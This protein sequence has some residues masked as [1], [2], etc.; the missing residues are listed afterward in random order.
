MIEI[1]IN[2]LEESLKKTS[3]GRVLD[4]AT[5]QGGFIKRMEGIFGDFKEIIGIDKKIDNIRKAESEFDD[6]RIKFMQM[7]AGKLDFDSGSFDT[8]MMSHSLHHMD[9]PGTVLEEMLRVLKPS[10]TFIIRELHRSDMNELQKTQVE[11]HH[12]WADIDRQTG[13]SH[14]HTLTYDKIVETLEKLPIRDL[15][16]ARCEEPPVLTDAEDLK[17]LDERIEE[18]FV[19]IRDNLLEESLI[20][21]GEAI[22]NR[23]SE[24]GIAWAPSILA[25]AAK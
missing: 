4:I 3:A 10:G 22:R 25:I 14:Y 19:R 24:I 1:E 18:Y 23:I 13:I 8:V 17:W 12:W 9:K 7:D 2:K 6:S 5:G 20:K 21:R 15:K 11:M 16:I